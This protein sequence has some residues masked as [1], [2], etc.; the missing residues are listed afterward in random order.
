MDANNVPP[1]VEVIEDVAKT[2]VDP[3]PGNIIADVE[4]VLGLAK[5]LK[6]ALSGAHPSI[7][8]LV[9]LLF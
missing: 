8:D 1:V 7:I 4:V 9:R 6:E 2:V 3:S 5:Q